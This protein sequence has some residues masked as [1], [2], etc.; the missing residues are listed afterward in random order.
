MYEAFANVDK[1][2]KQEFEEAREIVPELVAEETKFMDFLRTENMDPLKAAK[3]VAAYWKVRKILF[4]ERWLLPMNQVC[5][6]WHP[7]RCD[8]HSS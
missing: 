1:S 5:S 7:K 4:Q 2:A 3:R 6:C 8:H